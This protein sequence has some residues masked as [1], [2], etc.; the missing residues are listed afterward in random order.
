MKFIFGSIAGGISAY[1][2]A[3]NAGINPWTGEKIQCND[4]KIIFGKTSNQEYHTFR[5][6]DK[7]NIGRNDSTY[8]IQCI[9]CQMVLYI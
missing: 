9:D 3:K 6:T 4:S 5:H 8:S 7:P 2:S 1:A